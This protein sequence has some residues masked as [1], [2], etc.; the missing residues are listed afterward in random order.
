MSKDAF[1]IQSK[2]R[3]AETGKLVQASQTPVGDIVDKGK[4]WWASKTVIASIL[5]I[6]SMVAGIFGYDISDLV[7]STTDLVDGT[8]QHADT[9]YVAGTAIVALAIAWWGRIKAIFKIK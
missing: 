4:S 2:I 7:P 5:G 6:L 1:V 9:I 3:A 8:A